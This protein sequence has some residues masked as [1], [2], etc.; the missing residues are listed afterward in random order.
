MDGQIDLSAW[1]GKSVELLFTTTPGPSGNTA[2]DW[3]AWSNFHFVGQAPRDQAPPFKLI[4][5]QEE[6]IYRYDYVLPRAAIYHHAEMAEDEGTVLDKL[7][8]PSLDVFDSVVLNKSRL[9]AN[10]RTQVAEIN[11]EAPVRVE[12]ASIRSYH[13]QKDIQIEASLDRSGIPAL[14]EYRLSR[15]GLR[16]SMDTPPRGPAQ[17]TCFAAY[18]LGPANTLLNSATN[19]SFRWGATMSLGT[20]VLLITGFAV[21]WSRAAKSRPMDNRRPSLVSPVHKT[22][23]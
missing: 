17:I 23:K 20:L 12:A 1:S 14:Y 15:L 3:A 7:V 11:R 21:I 19:R 13:S 4:Y 18:F 6:K 8:D 16:Q 9:T 22:S 2:Y 5:N 10:E